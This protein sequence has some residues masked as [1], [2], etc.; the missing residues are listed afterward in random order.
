MASDRFTVPIDATIRA[1]VACIDSNERGI[2]VVTDRDLR[3]IGT[4]TDGDVR[5]CMLNGLGMD[6]PLREI[7]E[8]KS[9][10]RA[11]RPVTAS[12]DL[13]RTKLLEIML[14][15]SIRQVPIVDPDGRFLGLVTRDEL[16]DTGRARV[17]AVVMA[18]GQGTRLRPLTADL[19]KPM[20]P[21][22]ERPL[23]EHIL[24]QLRRSGI[25]NVNVTT[26]YLADKIKEHFG[27][28]QQYGLE[29]NYVTEERP[30]GTAGAIGYLTPSESPLLVMNGDV[31]TGVDFRSM[32]SYHE[33]QK[34]DLTVA[35]RRHEIQVPYGVIQANDGLVSSIE[36]K[37][38]LALFVNAGIYLLEPRVAKTI[39]KGDRLDMTDVIGRLL[40]EGR[41]VASFP[42]R[43][44]W[45]DIGRPEDYRK[46]NDD[47]AAGRVGG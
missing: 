17:D 31:L 33:E 1:A 32:L 38:T 8:Q 26:H 4:I 35:V 21:V 28:G 43:E 30:L 25:T 45:L 7:L 29:I 11:A 39:P 36:E 47:M 13:P 18:G 44:Y 2:A 5:R 15:H 3:V 22:G 6:A 37:P 27:D 16:L 14:E 24:D 10:P 12:P 40:A 19:P 9:R 20:L 46:A 23:L 42:L 34:A 41:R